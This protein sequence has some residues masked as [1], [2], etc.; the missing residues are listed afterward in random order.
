MTATVRGVGLTVPL[1]GVGLR[2]HP[3]L[4]DTA[5]DAGFTDLWTGESSELD[6]FSPL[7]H[8]AAHRPAWTLGTAIVSA[9]TRGPALTALAEASDVP[10]RLGIGSSSNVVVEQWNGVGF[11]RPLRRT[12]DLVRFLARVWDG[13]RVDYHGDCLDVVGFRLGRPPARRPR[14][15]VAALRQRML[16]LA[17]AEADGAILNWLSPGDTPRVAGIVREN[18]PDPEIVARL[19]AVVGDAKAARTHARRQIAAYLNVPVYAEFHRSLG[20]G[21]ALDAMWRAW[22]AGDRR[23]AVDSIPDAVVDELV[24]LGT[25][26]DIAAGVEAYVR[27]G[28]TTPVL[29]LTVLGGEVEHHVQKVGAALRGR[30]T[31]EGTP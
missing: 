31:I 25:H 12:R 22:A 21:E 26:D 8:A 13:D 17:G 10:V 30:L 24:L 27:A 28:I 15:L 23:A 20:R 4:L 19:F 11:D 29:A 3:P 9:F 14:V 7:V 5:W 16:A 18:G 1:S 2:D 6:G